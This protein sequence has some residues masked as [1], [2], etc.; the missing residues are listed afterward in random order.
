MTDDMLLEIVQ[1]LTRILKLLSKS[2]CVL[3]KM[4][5]FA[6]PRDI[7]EIPALIV[8][9]YLRGALNQNLHSVKDY[10]TATFL[11]MYLLQ[12]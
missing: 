7:D 4:I 3:T 6:K 1:R 11:V 2:M 10:S 8:L 12:L 5:T 9:F